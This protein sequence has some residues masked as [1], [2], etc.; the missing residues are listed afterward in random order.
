MNTRL[1]YILASLMGP[2]ATLYSECAEDRLHNPPLTSGIG[3]TSFPY[4]VWLSRLIA[5]RLVKDLGRLFF[6]FSLR[7][8]YFLFY[9]EWWFY[10]AGIPSGMTSGAYPV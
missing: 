2:L 5:M 1:S 4:L 9:W 6:F 8:F 7:L 10:A 3:G